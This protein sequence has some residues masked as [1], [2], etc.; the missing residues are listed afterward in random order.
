MYTSPT[1]LWYRNLGRRPTQC[2][3]SACTHPYCNSYLFGFAARVL[4][5]GSNLL[6]PGTQDA[7]RVK[8]LKRGSEK[9]P[10]EQEGNTQQ[11]ATPP[12]TAR[13]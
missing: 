10:L 4:P 3:L 1:C 2:L 9:H 13:L 11:G 6:M 8:K 12:R 5:L 7:C